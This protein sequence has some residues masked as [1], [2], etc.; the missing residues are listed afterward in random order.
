M[1]STEDKY[2]NHIGWEI[3]QKDAD[4]NRKATIEDQNPNPKNQ[5]PDAFIPCWHSKEIPVICRSLFC[6]RRIWRPF[7][8][9]HH[10]SAHMLAGELDVEDLQSC[11]ISP[12][13]TGSVTPQSLSSAFWGSGNLYQMAGSLCAS[14]IDWYKSWHEMAC[15]EMKLQWKSEN[16][17]FDGFSIVFLHLPRNSEAHT[18]RLHQNPSN[19][20]L[21]KCGGIA[22]DCRQVVTL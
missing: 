4:S 13:E 12:Q 7:A 22:S 16:A 6:V 3:S 18:S 19:F 17:R 20:W 21:Q 2:C 5:T 10:P 9:T 14:V 11:A 1:L 8:A 15:I